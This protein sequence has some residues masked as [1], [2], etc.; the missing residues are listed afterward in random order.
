MPNNKKTKGRQPT[1]KHMFAGKKLAISSQPTDFTS[2]PWYNLTVR[3]ESPPANIS[4]LTIATA[5]AS[6]LGIGVASNYQMRLTSVRFWGALVSNSASAPLKPVVLSILD[7][8]GESDLASTGSQRTLEQ[9]TRYP[10]QVN[11]AAVGFRYPPAQQC[12]SL[13]PVTTF[14]LYSL[15]GAGADSVMYVDLRWRPNVNSSPA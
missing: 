5:I 15:V 9:F 12:V 3:I 7:P 13:A 6:Q 2:R 4:A 14:V 1:G 10:D 11:R 8:I